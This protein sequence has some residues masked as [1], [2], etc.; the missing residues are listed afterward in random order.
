MAGIRYMFCIA[1][2]FLL[3]LG[4]ELTGADVISS[5]S[6]LEALIQSEG[7]VLNLLQKLR[8]REVQKLNT[9]RE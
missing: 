5:M 2:F 6:D 7:E 9:A 3:A 4:I 8:S 1:W